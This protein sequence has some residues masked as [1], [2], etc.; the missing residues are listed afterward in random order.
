LQGKI[1]KYVELIYMATSSNI[2]T[3]NSQVVVLAPSSIVLNGDDIDNVLNLSKINNIDFG[4]L[5]PG[6]ISSTAI[7]YLNIANATQIGN[8]SIG[9]TN[10][11]SLT[12]SECTFGVDTLDYL[13]YNYVPQNSFSGINSSR[14]PASFYNISVPNSK[15][16]TS[17]YVYL[18]IKLTNRIK[19]KVAGTVRYKW[20]FNYG[21]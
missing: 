21:L 4:P 9:L 16:N 3:L 2:S 14:D 12:F 8:I 20:F 7:M 6:E 1:E 19:F 17:Q 10:I 13:D 18:N 5:S 15:L 11:G